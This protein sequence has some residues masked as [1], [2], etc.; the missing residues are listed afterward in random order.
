MNNKFTIGTHWFY[1][2]FY[3]GRSFVDKILTN[4]IYSVINQLEREQ[5]ISKFF[6]IRYADPYNH[7]RLRLQLN[8]T[9]DYSLIIKKINEKLMKFIKADIIWKIQVDTYEREIERYNKYLIEETESLFWID[10]KF[11]IEILKLIETTGNENFKWM[12]SVISTHSYLN[13]LLESDLLLQADLIKNMDDSFK[14]EFSFNE[15]N[16]K[17]LLKLYRE[18]RSTIENLMAGKFDNEI[19]LKISS[20]IK[21]RDSRLKIIFENIKNIS[22]KR[23][24][25]YIQYLPS[26]IH[27]SINRLIPENTRAHELLLY[28]YV[29]R[30][31]ESRIAKEK[32]LKQS[33]KI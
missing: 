9:D 27:M 25:N 11:S 13:L 21:K 24:L 20:L 15:N 23:K 14:K 16:S 29:S 22:K 26:Y 4:E 8:N 7:I 5:Y 3:I 33:E 32:Y 18:K 2:K 10:S 19:M 1:L 30:Y 31:Y 6:F 17:I 12:A 28:N